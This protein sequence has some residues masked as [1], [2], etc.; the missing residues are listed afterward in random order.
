[1]GKYRKILVAFDGSDSSRNALRQAIKFAREEQCW[2][3]VI[4]VAP[5][6]EGELDLTGVRNLRDA[7][8][9]PA[10][11]VLA[12]ALQIAE[13]ERASIMTGL[14]E[15]P[16]HERIVD[17]AETENCDLIVMGRRGR[18]GLEQTLLGSTAAR[19]IGH[20]RKDV[21][22]VPKNTQLSWD[23][24]LL[25]TD[26]SKFS[27]VAARHALNFAGSYG[28]NLRIISVV[29]I[30]DELFAEAPEL[31]DRLIDKYKGVLEGLKKEADRAGVNATVSIKE[32]EPA[33]KIIEEARE[34][35]AGV[36]F[37]GSHGR[38]GLMRLLMGSTTEKVIGSAPCPVI[39]VK[40]E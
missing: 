24:I 12:D 33:R 14:E 37:M 9:G 34:Q 4:S 17:V 23:G 36:I 22:I 15:G 10:E 3:K 21:L 7:L 30:T 31:Y 38:T 2:I 16:P 6:F 5:S 40:P 27:E 29:E 26:G 1:M 20:T 8:R 28:G 13:G 35:K 25:C 11:K 32:G 19:V 39:V 18:G